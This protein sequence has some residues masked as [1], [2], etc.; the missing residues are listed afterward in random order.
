MKQTLKSRPYV[1]RFAPSPTGELHFGS[2]LAATA[3]YLDAKA[4]HGQWLVRIEDIDKPREIPGA[5]D[6]ILFQ[7]DAYG[8]QWDGHIARQSANLDAYQ[9]ALTQLIADQR[10]FCCGCTR[11]Q[12]AEAGYQGIDGPVYPGTCRQGLQGKSA[13]TWRFQV[14]Q[15]E[16]DFSDRI[17]GQL[18]QNIAR[19]VGDFVLRRAD[20]LFAYQLAVVVDDA[21]Q[22]IT[23]VVRGADLLDSTP[24]QQLLQIALGYPQPRYAH[25]PLAVNP[26]QQKLSKQNRAPA[27]AYPTTGDLL[28]Q[29]FR[30]LGLNPPISLITATMPE[31]W[32]WGIANWQINQVPTLR[33]RVINTE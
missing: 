31:I 16:H 14:D 26:Q 30:F 33:Q 27:V 9:Q 6:K 10:A 13:R 32:H 21:C 17:Q 12:V 25:F 18:S 4:H 19:D 24:R 8:F 11:K 7:L 1:G 3:S 5:A 28:I 15:T 20:G 22:G 23:D 29:A 2:L